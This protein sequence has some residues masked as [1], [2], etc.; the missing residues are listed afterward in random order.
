M[1]NN[2]NKK[3]P[4]DRLTKSKIHPDNRHR[5]D[6]S[7]RKNIADES[8]ERKIVTI[9]DLQE[10]NMRGKRHVKLPD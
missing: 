4:S 8:A 9:E 3:E 7:D 1:Q 2:V 5:A 10:E 6:Y